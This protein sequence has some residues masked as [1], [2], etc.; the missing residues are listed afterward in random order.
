MLLSLKPLYNSF[1]STRTLTPTTLRVDYHPKNN[2]RTCFCLSSFL[3]DINDIGFV[4]TNDH[5]VVSHNNWVQMIGVLPWPAITLLQSAFEQIVHFVKD[6]MD[7]LAHRIKVYCTF[8]LSLNVDVYEGSDLSA[9]ELIVQ[10]VW[11]VKHVSC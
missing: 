3:H 10:A 11:S 7:V 5:Y 4:H 8:E 9:R 6:S 1:L 2:L